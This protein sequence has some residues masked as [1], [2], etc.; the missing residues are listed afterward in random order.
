MLHLGHIHEL[1]YEPKMDLQIMSYGPTDVASCR[2]CSVLVSSKEGAGRVTFVV[3]GLCI[4]AFCFYV[5][6]LRLGFMVAR[7]VYWSQEVLGLRA[8]SHYGCP[9][10]EAVGWSGHNLLR[11]HINGLKIVNKIY[12]NWSL[13]A[14]VV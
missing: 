5:G 8:A 3:R 1:I 10:R 7:Y 14:G 11:V 4:S 6:A 2:R 12:S 9:S 13:W